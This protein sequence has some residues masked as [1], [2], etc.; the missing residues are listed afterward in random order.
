MLS[1][2]ALYGLAAS[3]AVRRRDFLL[4]QAEVEVEALERLEVMD[5][6]QAVQDEELAS[7]APV[8]DPVSKVRISM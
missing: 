1:T 7:P 8:E 2:V 3:E 4:L 6:A 5:E